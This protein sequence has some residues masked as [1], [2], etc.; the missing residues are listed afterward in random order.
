MSL[1]PAGRE[2]FALAGNLAIPHS[3]YPRT[4]PIAELVTGIT[5]SVPA[6]VRSID[7]LLEAMVARGASDLHLSVGTP[8]AIRVRGELERLEG[9]P[10]LTPEDTQQLLYRVL[11]TEQQ[12]QLEIKRQID[13]SHSVPG[14]ARFRVNVYFQR[15]ALGAAFRVIPEELKTLEE[16][17]L[18][19]SLAELAM[20]PRGLVLVTGPTGSGK[21]TTLAAMID[22]VNRNRTDHILTI[23]DPIEFV[24]RHKRCIVNQREIGVDAVSFGEALRAALRQD[25]DVILVGEMRDLETIGTALTAAE[26]GHLVLGTL[27][28]QSAPGTVDRIID[29][30][31]AEQQEQVRIMLAGS[32]QGI[33]T[34]AL[35]PTADQQGRVAALEILLPDD[36]TR[37]LIRQGKVEQIY[38]IMQTSTGRGMT[39]M[40]QSLANLVLR[41]VITREAALAVSSRVEQLDGLLERA[42][43]EDAG[44]GGGAAARRP[45]DRRGLTVADGEKPTSIWKKELSLRKKD[46]EPE[47]ELPQAPGAPAA[48]EPDVDAAIAALA[49]P[50]EPVAAE[51][52]PVAPPPA[53]AVEH[54]WL[55]Q[56]LEEISEPPADGVP[57]VALVPEAAEPRVRASRS[58][59]CPRRTRR[60]ISSPSSTRS[61]TCRPQSCP[62]RSRSPRRSRRP[63][64]SSSRRQSPR[65]RSSRR[66]RCP[67][68][69]RSSS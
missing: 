4:L 68:T 41:R 65:R 29:V 63:C 8:P 57:P 40:E 26:T 3:S 18:P 64:S 54:G 42:G 21:S 44:R 36:A 62:R 39:T 24:H 35:I 67:S 37:N 15:E 27:H 33:I 47:P 5:P 13:T 56:P 51:A 31:P 34:Q 58:R 52:P 7:D 32:L 9:A 59:P 28:T 61:S 11:S 12:K 2:R 20:Q 1:V 16:L 14:L 46:V 66:R 48:L 17:N 60:P 30:F 23:E 45:Q 19:R 49:L 53:P 38:S 25:P 50:A 69:R 43:F 6:A 22:E 10:V 55:T